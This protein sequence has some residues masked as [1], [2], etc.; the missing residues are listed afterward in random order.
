MVK[1]G[2][3]GASIGIAVLVGLSTVGC[4]NPGETTAIASATGGAFGA[5]LGAIIGHQTGD[6]GAGLALGA[7][8][9][10]GAGAVIGNA[11]EVQEKAMRTQDEAIER[12]DR[13][14]AAQRAEL[15]ELR[16]QSGDSGQSGWGARG[17]DLDNAVKRELG[18]A[19]DGNRIPWPG[20]SDRVQLP[21]QGQ[22]NF[23]GEEPV[24]SRREERDR[25]AL[26]GSRM[27]QPA[28][29][30]FRREETPSRVQQPRF[31]E[32]EPIARVESPREVERVAKS[33]QRPVAV[34]EKR[35]APVVTEVERTVVEESEPLELNEREPQ[36]AERASLGRSVELT[37]ECTKARD[38]ASKATNASQI[39]D[40]LY[41]FRRALRLC[42]EDPGYHNGLGEVYLSLDRKEDA[43]YEFNE[44]LKIDPQYAAAKSNLASAQ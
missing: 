29:D 4:T 42:P 28:R 15:E 2:V 16:K 34:L 14:I 35:A 19:G 5:G 27:E 3:R 20:P 36:V 18:A 8:A 40:K 11:L 43:L 1:F 12:Q 23:G 30:T 26:G 7:A 38:E 37:E 33:V 31:P 25:F 6:P 32:P 22:N 10:A 9:G 24:V 13:L 39:A 41:H 21:N 17:A 44:A